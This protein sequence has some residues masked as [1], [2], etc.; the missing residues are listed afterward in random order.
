MGSLIKNASFKARDGVCLRK[1]LVN[2]SGEEKR[3]RLHIRKLQKALLLRIREIEKERIMLK[4]FLVKLQKT[5]GYF[6]QGKLW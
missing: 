1:A 4:L 2:N 5:S 3:T 6:P